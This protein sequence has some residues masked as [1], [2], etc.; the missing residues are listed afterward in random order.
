M[1]TFHHK[2]SFEKLKKDNLFPFAKNM[3]SY[4]QRL[5]LAQYVYKIRGAWTYTAEG[6]VE[7]PPSEENALSAA[8]A[9]GFL[10][11][12]LSEE[13][14]SKALAY[15]ESDNPQCDPWLLARYLETIAESPTEEEIA[16]KRRCMYEAAYSKA[17]E[18]C[19]GIEKH[20]ATRRTLTASSSKAVA[21]S[22]EGRTGEQWNER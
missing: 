15:E 20:N 16:L 17:D 10:M 12:A 1:S 11:L 6:V 22:S 9:Y 3:R 5:K 19:D 4:L 13:R 8:S 7:T 21:G 14:K 2:L 18:A